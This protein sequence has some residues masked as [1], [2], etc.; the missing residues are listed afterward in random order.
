MNIVSALK[1]FVP[2]PLRPP[3]RR[4]LHFLRGRSRYGNRVQSEIETF[5]NINVL[6]TLPPIAH[7]WAHKYI[8]P[9]VAPFGFND[10]IQFFRTYM[11]RLCR[12]WPDETLSFLSIGAGTCADLALNPP[13]IFVLNPAP[14][15]AFLLKSAARPLAR[16]G[17]HSS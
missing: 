2:P 16:P 3:L 7:Y 5:T 10:A 4:C 6:E 8:P 13:E 12:Q 9:M 14:A 11:A 1:R 17:S 15:R